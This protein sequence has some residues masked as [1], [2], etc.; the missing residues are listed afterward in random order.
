MPEPSSFLRAFN[1][2]VFI[3]IKSV[4][5]S[6]SCALSCLITGETVIWAFNAHSLVEVEGL[7]FSAY[8]HT[9]VFVEV[10]LESVSAF[11]ASVGTT[12]V[13]VRIDS[14]TRFTSQ[15]FKLEGSLWTGFWVKFNTGFVDQLK[16]SITDSTDAGTIAFRAVFFAVL[17]FVSVA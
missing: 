10:V 4:S 17:A 3:E 12:V 5:L 2:L 6:A 13:T 1:T 14:L 16:F 7:S 9:D 11:E 15:I 8:W